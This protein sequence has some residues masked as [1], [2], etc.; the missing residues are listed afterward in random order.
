MRL[1]RRR[2]SLSPDVVAA[3]DRDGI[4]WHIGV[5]EAKWWSNVHAARHY[6]VRPA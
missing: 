5:L 2:G 4:Q 3:L 6:K 1:Y